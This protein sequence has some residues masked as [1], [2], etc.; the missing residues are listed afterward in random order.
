MFPDLK[1]G[2][3]A[4][5]NQGSFVPRSTVTQ[6][7]QELG[8]PKKAATERDSSGRAL[9][10]KAHAQNNATFLLPCTRTAPNPSLFSPKHTHGKK[11]SQKFL[12]ER[13]RR[14][15]GCE[16]NPASGISG[17][18][19]EDPGEQ[20][21]RDR[22]SDGPAPHGAAAAET[23]LKWRPWGRRVGSETAQ[24]TLAGSQAAPSSP[25]S[26][27]P[28]RTEELPCGGWPPSPGTAGAALP[29]PAK[30]ASFR[31]AQPRGGAERGA[32]SRRKGKASACRSFPRR[33][34]SNS[35]KKRHTCPQ[36]LVSFCPVFN[37]TTSAFC[38]NL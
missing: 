10:E 29:S 32:E 3:R 12:K 14:R 33:L 2:A 38:H 8:K 22:H 21:L 26:P 4:P 34:F 36:F 18:G 1:G 24:Q 13:K 37:M 15:G 31:A 25:L 20:R 23:A 19:S 7:T 9:S 11:P 5:R 27:T 16:R 17:S 28:T 30:P 6:T 35:S